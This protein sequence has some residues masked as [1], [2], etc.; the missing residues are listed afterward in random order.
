MYRIEKKSFNYSCVKVIEEVIFVW[1]KARIP[2]TRKD[3]AINK[4]KKLYNQW[5]N[6][7]KHK[8]R[9]TELHRQQES[10]F[11]LKIANLFDISDANATNKI[12]IDKD[13]RLLLAQREPGRSGFMSTEDVFTTK[14]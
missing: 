11:R 8:D 4:F 3:N 7:F 5:L 1:N 10:G 6:L 9:I 2:T 14:T 12:I 13:R